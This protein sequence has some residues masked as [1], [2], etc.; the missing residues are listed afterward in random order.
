MLPFYDPV[1]HLPPPIDLLPTLRLVYL[2]REYEGQ[3]RAYLSSAL[4]E[5]LNLRAYQP[6]SL[7]PPSGR[8]PYWHLDLRPEAKQRIAQ[9]ADT[10]PRIN[11]LK[12]PVGLVLPSEALILQ[13]VG[14]PAYPGFHPMLPAHAFTT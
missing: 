8:S 6:I 7:V 5:R 3:Y 13:L 2:G 12:L 9:Y 4:F 11:S 1:Q 14:Q 10:R